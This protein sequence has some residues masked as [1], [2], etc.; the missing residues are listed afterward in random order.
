M[1]KDG[2]LNF[3]QLDV[4]VNCY[5]ERLTRHCYAEDFSTKLNVGGLLSMVYHPI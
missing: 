4:N 2:M 5:T 1:M 3:R